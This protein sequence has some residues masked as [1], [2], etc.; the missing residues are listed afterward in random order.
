[1][2][3]DIISESDF[4]LM[5]NELSSIDWG[6]SEEIDTIPPREELEKVARQ[7]QELKTTGSFIFNG[8]GNGIVEMSL[9]ILGGTP[10]D[11]PGD[12]RL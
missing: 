12:Y 6:I 2:N 8:V 9:T 1:M 4:L 3:A 11:K 5:E 7:Q 10:L